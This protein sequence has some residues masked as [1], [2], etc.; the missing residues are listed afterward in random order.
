MLLRLGKFDDETQ[1]NIIV[2]EPLHVPL[3]E[4]SMRS[5][6]VMLCL[7]ILSISACQSRVNPT[8]P[9]VPSSAPA[10]DTPA[11]QSTATALDRWDVLQ[12][13]TPFPYSSPLPPFLPGQIDGTYAKIDPSPPQYWKCLRCADYRPVG[14]IW[15]IKFDRGVMRIYYEVTGWFSIASYTVSGNRLQLFND[16]FCPDDIGEYSWA[17]KDSSLILDDIDDQCAFGLRGQNLGN[18]PWPACSLQEGAAPEKSPPGCEIAA[19]PAGPAPSNLLVTV[20]VHGG[21]SRF[22]DRPPEVYVIANTADREPPQGIQVSYAEE[23]VAYGLHRILWWGGDWIEAKTDLPFTHMGVQII[24]EAQIGWARLLFDGVE[25][26]RGD[27]AAIW[28]R[29][30]R[31]GGYIEVSGFEPG[32]HTIRVESLGF[33]YRPVTIAGFGFSRE[34]GVVTGGP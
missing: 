20:R 3:E 28:E 13:E 21:D 34:V 7:L 23:A 31:H 15:R 24:G 8:A 19:P 25:V 10:T 6:N 32:L 26:W 27:T 11:R 1:W 2:P 14:G 30:G 9:P 18:Q 33:D 4:K 17:L 16:P 5:L 22:F 29:Y 12:M